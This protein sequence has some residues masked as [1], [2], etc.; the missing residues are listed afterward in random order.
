MSTA[1]AKRNNDAEVQVAPAPASETA[2]IFS[3][4]ER[5][6][7]DPSVSVERVEQ[8]FGLY[9]RMQADRAQKAFAAAFV[10][11]QSEM[12][13]VA[14]DAN[15]LQT[16]SRYATYDALDRALRPIYTKH[17]FGVSFNTEDGAPENHVRIVCYVVHQEGHERIHRLDMP[18][19]GKGAK[20]G[21]V[22]T[23]THAMGSAMTYGKRYLLGIAWNI[24]T[25]DR[26][27]DGNA[28]GTIAPKERI[29]EQQA[30]DLASL[31][32]R[33]NIDL[34]IIREH[35]KVQEL[36]DLTPAQLKT[37]LAKVNKK[38]ELEG[39]A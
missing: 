31:A 38:L 36:S 23:K 6:A 33:A 37:A 17:G 13:P 29:T 25:T 7:A 8:L 30:K 32:D 28:A 2:A 14:K 9:Q 24:A 27:D 11:A 1:I 5:V 15:N 20:G 3:M 4:I 26:D 35:F 10:A 18:C 19:D 12:D 34:Q 22:M 39:L 21:D 16:K